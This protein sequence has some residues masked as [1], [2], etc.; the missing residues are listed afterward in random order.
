LGFSDGGGAIAVTNFNSRELPSNV[1]DRVPDTGAWDLKTNQAL[2]G[3]GCVSVPVHVDDPNDDS[4]GGYGLDNDELTALDACLGSDALLLTITY[5]S[6]ALSNDGATL[7]FLDTDRNP[8][9]G[10]VHVNMAG[11]TQ[12]GVDY[13]V[14]TY[15][16][17]DL[18]QQVTTLTRTGAA[19]QTELKNQLTT[20]TLANRLYV[21]IPI[22][23]IGNPVGGVNLM[24][25]TAAWAGAILIPYD[26][27]P[28]HGVVALPSRLLTGDFDGDGDVDGA[29]LA[30]FIANPAGITLADF[31]ADYGKGG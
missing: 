7:I 20:V 6:Y 18:L 9:T 24:L 3:Q 2:P 8:T 11:D 5:K 28:N 25:Q 4:V 13:Y 21:T 27:L 14:L 26:D 12:I 10:D 16:Y 22:D 15:W 19:G 17:P 30:A 31:A 1:S 29:D 23:C